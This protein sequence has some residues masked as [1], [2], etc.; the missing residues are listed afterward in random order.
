MVKPFPNIRV[1]RDVKARNGFAAN[2]IARRAYL[3]VARNQ[4]LPPQ[5]RYQAQLQL[6]TFDRYT[7]STSVKNRCTET[8]RGRGI[9][10]EFGLCRVSHSALNWKARL[11]VFPVVPIPSEGEGRR[12][13]WREEGFVVDNVWC[14]HISRYKYLH[15]SMLQ[16]CRRLR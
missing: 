7:R 14:A 10:S 6:N 15:L 8:G 4:S 11:I 1:I 5:V 13:S 3:Y 12:D 16:S 2:E 9:I